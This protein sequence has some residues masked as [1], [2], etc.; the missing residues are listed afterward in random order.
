MREGKRR[1]YIGIFFA[2][3][4]QSQ[5]Q[6]QPLDLLI[7][8]FEMNALLFAFL[9]RHRGSPRAPPS[10]EP[11]ATSKGP[12]KKE[13]ATPVVGEWV[14]VRGPKRAYSV[15]ELPSPKNAQKRD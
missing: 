8:A 13:T 2:C 10:H 6:L 4:T 9:Y 14:E 15:F 3:N 1:I 5:L 7:A 12:P 11:R